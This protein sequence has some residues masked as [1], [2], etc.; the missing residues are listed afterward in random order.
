MKRNKK[1]RIVVDKAPWL[2]VAEY[3][4]VVF[5]A[6]GFQYPGEE[7]SKVRWRDIVR[8]AVGYEIHCIAISDWDFWAI[9]GSDPDVTYWV[10][11]STVDAFSQEIHRRF[12]DP[13]IPP[14]G[15]WVD[16]EFL[17]R[18]YTMWPEEEIGR[19]MYKRTK[20]HWWS[21]NSAMVYSEMVQ[22]VSKSL[23]TEEAR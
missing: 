20:R 19:P 17:I 8:V 16:R 23:N 3:H 15:E 6:E 18:A 4:K 21:W 1:Q 13:K 2:H 14:M 7:L 10:Y 9:Q 22:P 12:G 5:D 11:T